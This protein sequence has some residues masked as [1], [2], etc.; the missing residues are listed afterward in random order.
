[1]KLITVFLTLITLTSIAQKPSNLAV[2]FDSTSGK[3]GFADSAGNFVIKPDFDNAREF[4]SEYTSV[5]IDTLWGVIDSKGKY[6]IKPKYSKISAIYKGH[7]LESGDM[8][9]FRTI[10][11]DIMYEYL[12]IPG[13]FKKI[14]DLRFKP[15][16]KELEGGELIL[17][18]LEMYQTRFCHY[19]E[20]NRLYNWIALD[21][22][23]ALEMTI[24][25]ILA[26]PDR[27]KEWIEQDKEFEK[28]FKNGEIEC[29]GHGPVW[30]R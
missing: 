6:K 12:F 1:M 20:R 26:N 24:D 19:Y 7:F 29:C 2:K 4:L 9:K 30:Y 22:D 8:M 21:V 5:Q 18:V 25:Y 23:W 10:N 28:A 13:P 11:G 15:E 16:I 27:V 17:R 14:N 3:Y